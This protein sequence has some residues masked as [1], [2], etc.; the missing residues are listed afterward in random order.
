MT[1]EAVLEVII[2][3]YFPQ[4]KYDESQEG[5]GNKAY[6]SEMAEHQRQRENLRSHQR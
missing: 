5:N 4:G 3:A 2:T 1:E 6:H